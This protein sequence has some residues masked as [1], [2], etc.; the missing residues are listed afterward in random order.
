MQ[1]FAVGFG[2][3]QIRENRLRYLDGQFSG[4]FLGY[5]MNV[6]GARNLI[7]VD[8]IVE[9]AVATPL[10]NTLCSS[11][12]YFEN[13]TVPGQLLARPDPNTGNPIDPLHVPAR[14]V[15]DFSLFD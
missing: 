2:D 7:V 9:S 13:R 3:V 1:R 15:F 8:N 14:Y 11:I 12:S 6:R 5:L 10:Q 4:A